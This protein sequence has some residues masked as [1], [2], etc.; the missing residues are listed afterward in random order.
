MLRASAVSDSP[1]DVAALLASLVVVAA[2]TPSST[3]ARPPSPAPGPPPTAAAPYHATIRWTAHGVPHIVADDVG[4]LGF[5]QGYAQ[6]RAHLCEL[7][8]GYVRVRGERGRYLG[9]G[10]AD[11]HVQSD[12]VHLHLGYAARARAAL[13]TASADTRAMVAGFAAGYNL[14]LART[15]PAE[16]PSAC[17]GAAWLQPITDVDVV[18]YGLSI[19]RLASTRYLAGAIAAAQPGTAGAA[20]APTAPPAAAAC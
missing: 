7:A 4:G 12:L 2:C 16:Q 19:Q 18:A 9:R 15:P 13:P 3:P 6:A 1:V 14:A 10:P 11:A 8:D 5:G 20:L 17:R